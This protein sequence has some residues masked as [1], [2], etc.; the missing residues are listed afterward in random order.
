MKRIKKLVVASGNPAKVKY[1]AG[2]LADICHEVVG[3]KDL[4]IEGKP[5]ETGQTAEENARLKLEF[6]RGLIP[7]L[8]LFCEDEALYVDF[9]PEERQPGVF[10]RRV[11]GLVEATDQEL[12]DYWIGIVKGVPKERRTGRW[13]VAFALALPGSKI[14]IVSRD[15]PAVFFEEVSN[16]Y[17]PGW[18][19][20]SIQGPARF[21]KP[22]ADLNPEEQEIKRQ[23]TAE[24]IVGV[25]E[26]LL[27]YTEK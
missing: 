22:N 21:G 3:L 5:E 10:V 27:V 14:E 12:L 1:Y 19:M 7:D 15:H 11:N 4:G 13:H 16:N 8:P 20:N 26:R 2:A 9:L 23:E 25:M 18:P 24:E 17:H 6:Y